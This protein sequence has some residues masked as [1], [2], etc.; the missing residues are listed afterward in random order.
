MNR[1]YAFN[2]DRGKCR[3]TG[4]PL[5]KHNL[6]VHHINPNLPL[7]EVNKL[8]NLACVDK[9]IHKAIHNEVDMSSILNNKE[10]NKLKRFRN[11]IHAI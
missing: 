11:K 3:I 1:G 7:E 10:I 5:G 6:H 9:E 2:R 8:P 4:V